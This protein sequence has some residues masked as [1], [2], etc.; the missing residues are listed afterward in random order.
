MA[1]EKIFSSVDLQN[2]YDEAKQLFE[3]EIDDSLKSQWYSLKMA[4]SSF[5]IKVESLN[6]EELKLYSKFTKALMNNNFQ[7]LQQQELDL[8]FKNMKQLFSQMNKL[9]LIMV[10]LLKKLCLY[11]VLQ[12]NH[13]LRMLLN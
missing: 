12:Q 3:K 11:G 1:K 4:A 9:M 7:S 8:L 6:S 13:Q 2:I 5:L 10:I